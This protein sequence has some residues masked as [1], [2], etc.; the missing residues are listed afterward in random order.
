LLLGHLCPGRG[1][2]QHEQ[3]GSAERD[4]SSHRNPA[5]ATGL[6][7]ISGRELAANRGRR[8]SDLGEVEA[9]LLHHVIPALDRH[10]LH[11]FS[12]DVEEF[13]ALLHHASGDDHRINVPTSNAPIGATVVVAVVDEVVPAADPPQAAR[14]SAIPK[15]ATN[16]RW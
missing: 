3:Q 8:R 14:P 6:D 16:L 2:G 5:Q 12:I 11:R 9:R 13:A 7:E 10:P 15:T 4:E 1:S